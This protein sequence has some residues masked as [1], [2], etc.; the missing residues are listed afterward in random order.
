MRWRLEVYEIQCG[1]AAS[2]FQE[3]YG[4]LVG[5]A[6]YP[7]QLGADA[8]VVGLNIGDTWKMNIKWIKHAEEVFQRSQSP[9]VIPF[10]RLEAEFSLFR[11]VLRKGSEVS[12]L[13][14][15]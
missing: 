9:H 1:G 13:G 2:E 10:R 4:N 14:K 7:K 12:G 11:I 5:P 6:R 3:F 15:S 8:E